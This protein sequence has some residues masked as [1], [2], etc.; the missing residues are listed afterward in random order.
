LLWYW[1]RRALYLDKL[2]P[3]TG[4]AGPVTYL[5]YHSDFKALDQFAIQ[6][7]D[8]IGV[9]VYRYPNVSAIAIEN[10]QSDSINSLK[11]LP[12]VEKIERWAALRRNTPLPL[13]EA[14][15]TELRGIN[16]RVSLEEVER[17]YLPLSRLL[18]LHIAS[19]QKLN[20]GIRQFMEIEPGKVPFIIGI[21]GS[22]ADLM[23][24]KGFPESFDRTALLDFLADI[25]SGKRHLK[26]PVYSHLQYDIVPDKHIEV[27]QPDILIV[28]GLNVLQT[29]G[30]KLGESNVFVSDYFDFS[31]YIDAE[32]DDI[33]QW[34]VDRFLT[35]R[36]T[37][38][39]K[40]GAYFSHF[41]S[42]DEENAIRT[43]NE[44]WA[45]INYV[46][47]SENIQPTR[48]RAKLILHKGR[49]HAIDGVQLR[50]M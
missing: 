35:L 25:K 19:V 9:E 8:V 15:L 33:R 48:N 3:N 23:H 22:V 37:V 39:N 40:P 10:E 2:G 24:R 20:V 36:S 18:S 26:A 41:A 38:F 27:D 31:L 47:L 5:V 50:K 44:I 16:E 30:A 1:H 34:Y 46:N 14:E 21:A 4:E 42:L 28:E 17:V 6:R 11:S 45:S 32:A 43:A 29:R 7:D 13:T 12:Y 49:D